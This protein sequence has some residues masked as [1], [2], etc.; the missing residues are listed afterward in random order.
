MDGRSIR[1]NGIKKLRL[2]RP[3]WTVV[4]KRKALQIRSE[5]N[6]TQ[7]RLNDPP[8]RRLLGLRQASC[9]FLEAALLPDTG[10]AFT[11]IEPLSRWLC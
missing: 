8:S 5:K 11:N 1:L 7:P 10:L 4:W 2:A 9:R 3:F 6:R